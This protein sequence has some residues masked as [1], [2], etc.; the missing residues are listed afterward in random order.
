MLPLLRPSRRKRLFKQSWERN[1][2]GAA[3]CVR[4]GSRG[5][6]VQHS[7]VQCKCSA[8]QAV[9]VGVGVGVA[10]AVAVA[11][12]GRGAGGPRERCRREGVGYPG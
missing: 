11:V 9:G 8:V 7:A 1:K 4:Q 3:G 6:A 2:G 5:G 10:G 12:A